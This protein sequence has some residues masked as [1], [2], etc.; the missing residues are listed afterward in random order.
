MSAVGEY[1]KKVRNERKFSLKDVK[2]KTGIS[3]SALSHIESGKT[4]APSPEHFKKLAA[5]YQIDLIDLFLKAGYLD[6]SDLSYYQRCF[7]GADNLSED[8]HNAVQN[9]I[10]ILVKKSERYPQ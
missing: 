5:E 6:C 8:E 3:D 7:L 2:E 10:D 1:L 4:E 9:I